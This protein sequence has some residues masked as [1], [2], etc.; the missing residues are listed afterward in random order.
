MRW[1]DWQNRGGWTNRLLE[2]LGGSIAGPGAK[3]GSAGLVQSRE[4]SEV[5]GK[6]A[7]PHRNNVAPFGAQR[8]HD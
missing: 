7:V 3:L 4:M 2:G 1:C 6:D 5:I 8:R